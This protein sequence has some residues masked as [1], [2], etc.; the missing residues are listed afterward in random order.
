MEEA[1]SILQ[2]LA[3]INPVS[4]E[5]DLAR[6]LASLASPL[7]KLGRNMD[8]YTAT[9][10]SMALYQRLAARKSA[11]IDSRAATVSENLQALH[12]AL[13]KEGALPADV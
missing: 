5:P 10:E 13:V 7:V 8:A 1:V 12:A 3:E 9:L 2:R 11:A 6:I 4:R